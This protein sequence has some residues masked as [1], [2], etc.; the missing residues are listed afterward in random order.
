M[1]RFIYVPNL[2]LR[3]SGNSDEFIMLISKDVQVHYVS[4]TA[5]TRL[6]ATMYIQT[7]LDRSPRLFLSCGISIQ[8][9]HERYSHPCSSYRLDCSWI[10]AWENY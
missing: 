7:F 10:D 9:Y 2:T 3:M 4:V 8:P 5:A 1:T 6:Y